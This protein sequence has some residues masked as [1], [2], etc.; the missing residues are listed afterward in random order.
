MNISCR[1]VK[2]FSQG[3][4]GKVLKKKHNKKSQ[5]V[6]LQAAWSNLDHTSRLTRK[7]S[8]VGAS[9]AQPEGP[10]SAPSTL[11]GGG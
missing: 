6:Y 4:R 7:L 9:E 5:C 3:N 8:G 1:M 10:Q 11:G 2:G